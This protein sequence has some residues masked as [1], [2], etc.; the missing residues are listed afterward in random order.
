MYR[1]WNCSKTTQMLKT[2]EQSLLDYGLIVV[3]LNQIIVSD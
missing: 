2:L 1:K 3:F